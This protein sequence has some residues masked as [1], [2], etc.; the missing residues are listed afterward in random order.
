MTLR[1]TLALLACS[2]L[3]ACTGT[4]PEPADTEDTAPPAD[5]S[6]VE[7]DADA[8]S[9]ADTDADSDA[10]SDSD[11]DA[12]ADADVSYTS[13]SG[14]E[15]F[16]Y[17]FSTS[18][19]N[20]ECDMIWNLTGTPAAVG[21]PD[22]LFTFDLTFTYDK[23]NSVSTKSCSSLATDL[24]YTYGYVEDYYGSPTVMFAFNYDGTTYWYAFAD[25]EFDPSADTLKYTTG[26]YVDYAYSSY[27]TGYVT[28]YYTAYSTGEA[29][30]TR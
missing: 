25:A 17:D 26:G 3:F 30:L 10:D 9:D 1:L 21:C 2:T 29:Q 11:A 19:G 23:T 18:P 27:Y 4:K 15:T 20:R 28:Y 16:A 14:Y 6:A 7:G 8:D 13:W 12:D 24:A 5:D 22:C